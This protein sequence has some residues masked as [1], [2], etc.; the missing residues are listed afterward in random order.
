MT[1][2]EEALIAVIWV[3]Y[4]AFAAY[5]T[6]NIEKD[7]LMI[8]YFY[9]VYMVCSPIVFIIKAFHGATKKYKL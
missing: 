2:L 4:G 6:E 7:F 1:L 9:S 3:G 5:Q 8:I